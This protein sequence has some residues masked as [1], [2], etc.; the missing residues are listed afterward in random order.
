[1]GTQPSGVAVTPDGNFVY[2]A[3]ARLNTVEEINT[4]DN[5]REGN[6][7]VGTF[8][9]GVAVTPNG[10]EVY[11]TNAGANTVSV[12]EGGRSTPVPVGVAPEGVAIGLRH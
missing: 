12:L 6:F 7:V 4:F 1:V 10:L 9:Q 3:L 8:P 2:V 11:V 5:S